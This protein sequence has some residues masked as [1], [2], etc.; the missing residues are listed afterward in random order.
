MGTS[1]RRVDAVLGIDIGSTN[2][3]VVALDAR[4]HVVARVRRAT[5]RPADDPSIDAARLFGIIEEMAVAACGER[6]A[7]AG[8]CAAGVG[9][10]GILTDAALTP[11]TPALAWFDPRRTELFDALRTTLGPVLGPVPGAAP[12]AEPTPAPAPEAA[13]GLA[14]GSGPGPEPADGTVTGTDTGTVTGT[15]TSTSTSTSTDA[16]TGTVTDAA[17]TLVGWAWAREQPGA[18]RAS[19]WIALTDYVACRWSGTAFLSDT[20]AARTGA[21]C[22]LPRTWL[23]DRVRATL[24]TTGLLPPVLP[25]GT[26]VGELRSARL[27][28]AGLLAP[29]ALVV[30]GGHDHPVGGWGVDRLH[31]GAVLDS[32]GTAEVVVA[33]TPSPPRPSPGS[34]DI[35][36]GIHNPAGAT[37][38]RVE[39]LARNMQWASRDP[40]V[41]RALGRLIS[42][43]LKPDSSLHS[44]TFRPGA[45]GGRPPSYT[46]DAPTAPLSRASAVLGA[47]AA[48]GGRAVARVQSLT[49]PGAPVY[50]AGGWAR[51]PGWVEV[52]EAVTG[53]AARTIAEP[54]VTA[55]G[56]ALLAAHALGWAPSVTTAL[57]CRPRSSLSP[58]G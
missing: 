54:E 52:K 17:R 42:G 30:A 35:S 23:A 18:D 40:D 7:V 10:D 2:V 44:G 11:L 41:A 27:A 45:A 56:A 48:L 8:A 32:M 37:V 55:V 39:E 4:G 9:E 47:L 29:G 24:G 22:P 6:Y 28:D 49:A 20:L 51:S 5:P 3:K 25:T 15:S 19:S 50:S 38:L 12:G 21:W 53:R 13:L 46:P 43:D 1:S 57:D 26:A 14:P 34:F 16:D 36:P 31:P 33:Q 58:A